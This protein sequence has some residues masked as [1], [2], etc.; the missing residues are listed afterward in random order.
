MLIVRETL[1]TPK[2]FHLRITTPV[3]QTVKGIPPSSMSQYRDWNKGRE[4]HD[5]RGKE[6][7]T[8]DSKLKR[9]HLKQEY[10]AHHEFDY[11]TKTA[12]ESQQRGS[13]C[14]VE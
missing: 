10:E 13:L 7:S 5:S 6:P 12:R 11:Q 1:Y 4:L 8:G 14:D 9:K 2:F 3:N